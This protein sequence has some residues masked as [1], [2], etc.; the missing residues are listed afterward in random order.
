MIS[1]DSFQLPQNDLVEEIENNDD[2]EEEDEKAKTRKKP[3]EN[4]PGIIY[5]STIPPDFN[6]SRTT[7][8]FSQ[9][10]SVG[11]VFLQ[12]GELISFKIL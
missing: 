6:V 2:D 9:F 8:F 1:K 11:R 4:K 7:E 3:L 5:L 10:G 12:P